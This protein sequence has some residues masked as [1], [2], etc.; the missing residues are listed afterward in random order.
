MLHS[1]I[2]LDK[3]GL[4]YRQANLGDFYVQFAHLFTIYFALRTVTNWFAVGHVCALL[5]QQNGDESA[6]ERLEYM[7]HVVSR[8]LVEPGFP[9]RRAP[10][11]ANEQECK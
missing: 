9:Q 1:S 4:G 7:G 10:A 2:P 11:G 6:N 5:H 8:G 3:K